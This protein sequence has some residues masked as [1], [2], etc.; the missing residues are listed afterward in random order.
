MPTPQRLAL[1]EASVGKLAVSEVR[2]WIDDKGN[3]F[4]IRPSGWHGG[5]AYSGVAATSDSLSNAASEVDVIF[6]TIDSLCSESQSKLTVSE[7]T[8]L[9]KQL[10]SDTWTLW[11]G[12]QYQSRIKSRLRRRFDGF[13]DG[14]QR[15]NKAVMAMVFLCRIRDSVSTFA[16]AAVT[17]KALRSIE[18]VPV[19][20]P[21]RP[22]HHKA[23]PLKQMSLVELV[24]GRLGLELETSW[25]KYLCRISTTQSFRK[26]W[27]EKRHI[28]AEVQILHHAALEPVGDWVPHA[29]IGC[30]K[31]C[32]MVC[33]CFI[34][35][36]GGFQVRGTHE[37][38]FHRWAMPAASGQ[39]D[40]RFQPAIGRL[41]DIIKMALQEIL[42]QSYQNDQQNMLPQSS[43]ALSTAKTILDSEIAMMEKSQ[44][45]MR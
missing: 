37:A 11:G 36:Y 10:I 39:A 23:D 21:Q 20:V 1:S 2:T 17:I 34:L 8:S 40:N 27:R 29:Y 30:S 41:L 3:S 18:C 31:R 26:I 33:Y 38:V 14:Q 15:Y 28:H 42:G 35:S 7:E 43:A 25:A 16:E 4:K 6:R 44:L 32:C 5:L 24:S 19:P 12:T 45:N 9:L 13:S 22:P